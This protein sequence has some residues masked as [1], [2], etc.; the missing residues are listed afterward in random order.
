M[1]RTKSSAAKSNGWFMTRR[2]LNTR[3]GRQSNSSRGGVK[4]PRRYR[5]GTVSLREIHRYQ[6]SFE[7]LIPKLNFQNL[8]REITREINKELRFQSTALLALQEAGP[9]ESF[10]IERFADSQI[11]ALHAGRITIKTKD[12]Q[13]VC[14]MKGH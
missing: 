10:L 9:S 11:A 4:K 6:K 3:Y 8:V 7:L 2:R 12:M 14:Y 13:L 1:T 5:P